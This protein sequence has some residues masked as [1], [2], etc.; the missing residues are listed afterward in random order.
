MLLVIKKGTDA[1]NWAKLP[2]SNAWNNQFLQIVSDYQKTI[3]GVLY[4]HTHMDE[5]RRLYDP[6]G[7]KLLKLLLV[8]PVL[9][10]FTITILVLN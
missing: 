1:T 9:R 5:L 7:K 10:R 4:G 2:A 3:A 6:S 8:V